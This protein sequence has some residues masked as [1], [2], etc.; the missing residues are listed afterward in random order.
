MQAFYMLEGLWGTVAGTNKFPDVRDAQPAW[1]TK[2]ARAHAMLK[3]LLEDSQLIIILRCESSHEAWNELV[4]R[5]DQPTMQNI[6]LRAS[7]FRDSKME[8]DGDMQE[9]INLHRKLVRDLAALGQVSEKLQVMELI[10]SLLRFTREQSPLVHD[11][12]NMKPLRSQ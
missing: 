4:S 8:E 3:L 5:Y 2:D 12:L 1:K 10:L 6:V 9:H 7:E 11:G